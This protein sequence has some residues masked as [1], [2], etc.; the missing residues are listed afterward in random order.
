[1]IIN[2]YPFISIIVLN[3]NSK[4][5]LHDCLDSLERINYPKNRYEI[6][7]A[8]NASSD[9][10]IEYVRG[11][12]QWVRIVK[13]DENYG[14]A[15]GNNKAADYAMGE[16]ILF[17][18]PDTIVD[19][20]WLIELAKE[21]VKSNNEVAIYGSKVLYMD[22]PTI[23]QTTGLTLTP[24][25]IGFSIGAGKS[26]NCF[27]DSKMITS[28][29]GCSFLIKKSIFHKLGGFDS[30]YFA[31]VEELDLG[32]RAWLDGFKVI[33]VP[34]SILYHKFGGN[35][36]GLDSP[37]RIFFSQKNRLATIVKNFEIHNV[38]KG[39]L[40]SFGF[41]IIRISTFLIKRH[42]KGV[43][44]VAK[45]NYYFSKE[46]PKTIKKRKD[47]QANRKLS[48]AEM[49]KMGLIAPIGNCINEYMSIVIKK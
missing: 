23:I 25:G 17:L 40:I 16:Y 11:K 34:T 9:D 31:Y 18:N 21:I 27:N 24:M 39:L 15:E 5:Y 14:Y 46:L 49:Y 3:Y 2:E 44:A 30:D 35:W 19:I 37:Y 32:Y 33:Y 36:G 26:S 20:N 8:D 29:E 10:S 7:L 45:G 42:F 38:I 1:M 12:F 4:E 47:I 43:F 6:I 41:D 22:K 48:D 28:A 13:F